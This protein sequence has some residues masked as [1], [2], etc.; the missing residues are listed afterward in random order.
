MADD[1]RE[2]T[3]LAD[4]V[5]NAVGAETGK[6]KFRRYVA[7]VTTEAKLCGNIDTALKTIRYCV[8]N[9]AS[10]GAP[11]N[12]HSAEAAAVDCSV[13]VGPMVANEFATA[14]RRYA[15]FSPSF[16][17]MDLAGVVERL[18]W[19]L[20]RFSHSGK[21]SQT[22]LRGGG[23]TQVLVLNP[24]MMAASPAK[25]QVF[26][27]R[28]GDISQSGSTLCAIINAVSGEGSVL[29]TDVLEI[30][31]VHRRV[32][33]PQAADRDLALGCYKA[34]CII[35]ANYT[36]ANAGDVF[37]YALV[38]GVNRGLTVAGHSDEGAYLRN[39]LKRGRFGV[40]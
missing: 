7:H 2:H 26:M 39:V 36:H 37:A 4:T 31:P 28:S 17:K 40:P 1:T 12:R 24:T 38:R 3:S 21:L 13:E 19:A 9:D 32:L 20:A 27:P 30:D 25:G 33:L 14:A 5:T 10:V 6:G 15:N 35:G 18:G 22:A 8:G 34:L 23:G 16:T 29:V 11:L